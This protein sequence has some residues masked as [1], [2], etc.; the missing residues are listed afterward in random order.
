M[1]PAGRGSAEPESTT[2]EL[3]RAATKD[4]EFRYRLT[5]PEEVKA[6]LG[7]PT[8]ERWGSD[9]G[10]DVLSLSY[11]GVSA[12]FGR[13]KEQVTLP[14]LVRLTV[15]DETVDIG[16]DQL[17]MLRDRSDL[18]R[19]DPFRGL[20]NVS[21]AGLDLRADGD[22]LQRLPFDSSTVWPSAD[23][24]PPGFD[25]KGLL[26]R[27][28]NPGLGLWGLHAQGVDGRGVGLAI[29]D[30]PLLK[31]H[32][33]YADRLVAH[34]EIDVNGFPPQYHGPAVTSMA[35]GKACGVAPQARLHYYAIPMWKWRSCEPYRQVIL[36]ILERNA[37]LP[38]SERVRVVSISQG[39]FPDWEGY[40]AWQETV[41][42][43]RASG[44]LVVTCDR[45]VFAYGT[46][47]RAQDGDPDDPAS[48]MPGRYS[49]RGDIL[50]IPGA[51]R[52]VAHYVDPETYKYEWDGG[53]SLA[54][55]YLAGL[56]ALG[57]Q[58]DPTIEP[59]TVVSLWL[60]TATPTDAVPIISPTGFAEAVRLR[61]Q[62]EGN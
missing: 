18:E 42:V 27:G 59:D 43:A 26:E 51:N 28:K 20:Q 17:V 48:Y 55:P 53:M 58:L 13:Q 50:R 22:L 9:G 10:M 29:I 44:V 49:S 38:A 41:A 5:T 14:T 40:A 7:A 16:E 3:A 57:F 47:G 46:L 31:E 11:P 4:G 2:A 37:A 45:S 23:R 61:V 33:E 54:A 1:V 60:E 12:I 34:E 8:E 56:A 30:Q 24:L 52:A 62:T 6:L 15:D 35:V 25:P 32:Q 21:L 19:V 39:Q 36:K